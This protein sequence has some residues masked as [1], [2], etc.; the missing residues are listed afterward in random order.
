MSVKRWLCCEDN[1][2]TH[3]H[4]PG[5]QPWEGLG[6]AFTRPCVLTKFEKVGIVTAVGYAAVSFCS[7]F[8]PSHFP[9]AVE[10]RGSTWQSWDLA[11]R[12]LMWRYTER[13]FSVTPLWFLFLLTVPTQER[14]SPGGPLGVSRCGRVLCCRLQTRSKRLRKREEKQD[15]QCVEPQVHAG[16]F[17]GM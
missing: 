13:K 16:K 8:L 10:V 9:C 7:G 12:K 11:K 17:L 3:W 14:A 2:V 6:R 1:R 4:D 5:P 15:Q